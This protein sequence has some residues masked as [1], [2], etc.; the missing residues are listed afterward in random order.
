MF[1]IL[2]SSQN[3]QLML[4]TGGSGESGINTKVN[5]FREAAIPQ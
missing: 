3:L 2:R 1:K 4:N 5:N